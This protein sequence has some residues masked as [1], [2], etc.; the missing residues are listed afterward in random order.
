HT[1]KFV[2][3]L[4][5]LLPNGEFEPVRDRD[6]TI[7]LTSEIKGTRATR[8]TL[9]ADASGRV[10]GNYTFSEADA[11]DHYTL[12]ADGFTGSG[13]VLLGE[14]R[15][16]KVGLA[17]KGELKDGKLVLTFEAKDYLDRPVKGTSATF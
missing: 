5:T 17:I 6:V 7:N 4:R 1:L 13:R 8:L 9:H 11:L 10:T 15:K 3:F 16:A 14:Y 2:A 12:T